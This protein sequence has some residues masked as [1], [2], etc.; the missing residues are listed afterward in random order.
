MYKNICWLGLG[1]LNVVEGLEQQQMGG[2]F[3]F[4]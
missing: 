4:M 1:K 2:V 3:Y